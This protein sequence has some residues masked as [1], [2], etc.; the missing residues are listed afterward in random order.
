[1]QLEINKGAD[2]VEEN[3]YRLLHPEALQQQKQFAKP[4]PPGK[5]QRKLIR[6]N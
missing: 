6:I 4:T 5:G 1:L 2:I 3:V